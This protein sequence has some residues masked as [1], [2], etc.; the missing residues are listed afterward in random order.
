MENANYIFRIHPDNDAF[1]EYVEILDWCNAAYEITENTL[2]SKKRKN[3]VEF[4]TLKDEKFTLID[5]GNDL[6]KFQKIVEYV[7]YLAGFCKEHKQYDFAYVERELEL[8]RALKEGYV[9]KIHPKLEGAEKYVE[10]LKDCDA[11]Y[12]ITKY[13]SSNYIEFYVEYEQQSRM[14]DVNYEV[15][16]DIANQVVITA[17]YAKRME[18]FEDDIDDIIFEGG[19]ERNQ[20]FW[21]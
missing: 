4:W 17:T 21:D 9:F 5:A 14:Y 19:G 20:G 7:T 2:K 3:K 8:E 6:Q 16:E 1:Y 18:Q 10:I 15:F 13:T 11:K 12:V